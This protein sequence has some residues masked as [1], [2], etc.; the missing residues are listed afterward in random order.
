VCLLAP[1]RVLLRAW[2]EDNIPAQ[3]QVVLPQVP[4]L[5]QDWTTSS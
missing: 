4:V 5:V 2:Q 3:A 1:A